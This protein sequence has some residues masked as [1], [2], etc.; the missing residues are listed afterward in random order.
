MELENKNDKQ[1]YFNRVKGTITELNDGPEFCSIT[2]QCGHENPRSVNLVTKKPKFN[3]L[4]EKHS[5]GDRVACKF[6][7]ASNKKH[8]RWHT[9]AILL[10]IIFD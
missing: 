10:S 3:Q 4:K 7:L 9:S 6:Y 1:V 2:L 5:L 8:E